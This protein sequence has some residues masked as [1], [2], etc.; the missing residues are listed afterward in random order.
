MYPFSGRFPV[1][2]TTLLGGIFLLQPRSVAQDLS[3]ESKEEATRLR[4]EQ[5]AGV[6]ERIQT[7]E[8]LKERDKAALRA[9]IRRI[10]AYDKALEDWASL[11]EETRRDAQAKAAESGLSIFLLD[12]TIKLKDQADLTKQELEE[13]RRKLVRPDADPALHRSCVSMLQE[14]RAI[15]S[16]EALIR[17]FEQSQ[18]YRSIVNSLEKGGRTEAA[19]KIATLFVQNPEAKFF[20]AD[21]ELLI[22]VGYAHFAGRVAKEEVDRLVDLSEKDLLQIKNY[23]QSLTR[24]SNELRRLRGQKARLVKQAVEA[25]ERDVAAF[26]RDV[27]AFNRDRAAYMRDLAVFDRD[28]DAFNALPRDQRTKAEFDRLKRSRGAL[29]KRVA[30][31][32]KRKADLEKRRADLKTRK[33]ASH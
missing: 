9:I 10:P 1:V 3:R 30:D 12:R 24:H 2:A 4:D 16:R 8:V 25:F 13:L 6:N 23:S 32:N 26:D 27:T 7:L 17:F 28:V 15:R 18:N 20:L 11:T 19:V 21:G 33:A 22:A 14:L 5:L 29:D 31:L